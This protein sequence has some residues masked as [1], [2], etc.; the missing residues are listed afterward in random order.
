MLF[1][2][3]VRSLRID[4]AQSKILRQYLGRGGMIVF[5]SIATCRTRFKIRFRI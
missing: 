5:D 3:G 1:F 2:S 4:E